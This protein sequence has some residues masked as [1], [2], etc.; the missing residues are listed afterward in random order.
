MYGRFTQVSA[1]EEMAQH[2]GV[3]PPYP[4][5]PARYNAAPTQS[6]LT[7]LVHPKTGQRRLVPLRCGL[8]PYWAKDADIGYRTIN[9]KAES[10]DTKPAFRD[11]FRQRRC[12]VPADGFY[13]WKKMGRWKQ[14]YLLTMVDGSLFAFAGLWERWRDPASSEV[15][16]TFTIITTEPNELAAPIHNRMPAIIGPADYGTWLG[17]EPAEKDELLA[18]LKPFPAERMR[19]FPVDRRVGDP[20]NED[21]GLIEPL[22]LTGSL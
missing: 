4:N 19:A 3:L 7:V 22:R 16:R 8:I 12:L 9:A 15:V 21:A 13:E 2:F 20:K 17:E 18:L 6:L 14:P 10:I 5:A 11:A 1:M